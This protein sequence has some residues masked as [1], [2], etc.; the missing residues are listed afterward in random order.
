V[1]VMIVTTFSKFHR[2]E[3][4]KNLEATVNMC[5]GSADWVVFGPGSSGPGT[6]EARGDVRRAG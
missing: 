4:Y 2:N 6:R 5:P 1:L 3:G